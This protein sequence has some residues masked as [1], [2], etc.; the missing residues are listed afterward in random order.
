MTGTLT[1]DGSDALITSCDGRQ[2]WRLRDPDSLFPV[3]ADFVSVYATV[4]E[5]PADPFV[6]SRINYVPTEGFRCEF[7]WEG[8][9][10][11]AAGNE[12]FWSVIMTEDGLTVRMPAEPPRVVPFTTQLGPVF[13]GDGL[14]V[15]FT[16][17]L[18]ADTMVDTMFGW[19]VT[20]E[21]DNRTLTGCGFEGMAAQTIHP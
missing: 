5:G 7:D 9:L 6:A 18:C 8:T 19:S 16:P 12:P 10:W 4:P 1:R 14:R 2:T 15:A 20:L 21:V 17:G 13:L 11:R 3:D